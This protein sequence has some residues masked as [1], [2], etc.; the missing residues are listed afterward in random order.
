MKT[1]SPKNKS[2]TI[3]AIILIIGL[4]LL[5]KNLIPNLPN[6]LLSWQLVFIAVGI[7]VGMKT[8]FKSLV[9]IILIAIG[10]L[11]FIHQYIFSIP[12]YR[13]IFLPIILILIGIKLITSNNKKTRSIGYQSPESPAEASS[14]TSMIAYDYSKNDNSNTQGSTE[15]TNNYALPPEFIDVEVYFGSQSTKIYT[16]SFKKANINLMFGA[17]KINFREADFTEIVV[18]DV[19]SICGSIELNMPS[20]WYIKNEITS[21]LGSVEDN[22]NTFNITPDITKI[23]ILRGT[24]VMSSIEIKN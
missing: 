20:N 3:G 2:A 17:S 21:I 14:N 11:S 16:K 1:E 9:P 22:R 4:V 10:G 15:K 23:M 13:A 8:K 24:C 5:I 18:V 19:L 7:I 6:F 12:H